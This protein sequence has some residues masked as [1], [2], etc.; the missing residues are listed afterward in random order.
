MALENLKWIKN[1]E[2]QDGGR[3][4][5]DE[6]QFRD[7]HGSSGEDGDVFM[8]MFWNMDA[9][10]TATKGD[11][12]FLK[13]RKKLTHLIE[14]MTDSYDIVPNSIRRNAFDRKVK[15]HWWKRSGKEMDRL[16]NA[17]QILD[18]PVM[19]LRGV[20]KPIHYS[21]CGDFQ[22]RWGEYEDSDRSFKQHVARNLRQLGWEG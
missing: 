19:S 12:A 11:M 18:Y 5:Y 14:F 13:Q 10:C 2:R 15:I 16:P 6:N 7:A 4:A 9:A 20:T 8:L 22:I 17:E 1:I 3:W 21:L